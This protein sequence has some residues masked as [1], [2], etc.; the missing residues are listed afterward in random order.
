MVQR[1]HNRTMDK[2]VYSDVKCNTICCTLR[3]TMVVEPRLAT[4][5]EMRRTG[6][7][8]VLIPI[9][10]V[11]RYGVT[12]RL[13]NLAI[14]GSKR[15][16]RQLTYNVGANANPNCTNQKRWTK[17]L[18]E[19]GALNMA[20]DVQWV[21]VLEA[22]FAFRFSDCLCSSIRCCG[23]TSVPNSQSMGPKP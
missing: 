13:L 1:A 22:S 19:R 16:R 23:T 10:G 17:V 5:A 18:S 8:A 3:Y 20:P 6:P 2:M 14:S 21:T 4:I 7:L 9:A 12:T 15:G 11:L